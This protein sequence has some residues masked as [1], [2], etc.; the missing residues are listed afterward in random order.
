MSDLQIGLAIIGG[1]VIA[2]VVAYNRLQESRFRKRAED[3]LP[4]RGV[5]GAGQGDALLE[6][7]V[8]TRTD[9]IEPHIKPR[10][11]PEAGDTQDVQAGRVEPVGVPAVPA[12]AEDGESPIDYAIAVRCEQPLERPAL[13]Q[14]LEA[15]EGL[16]R[17]AEVSA[18][19]AD[20]I[21]VP[22]ANAPAEASEMRVALQLADRR[23]HVTLQDLEAFQNLVSRW[24]ES[25]GAS[26]A[27]PDVQAYLETA[28][29]LDRFCAEVDVVVGLNVV[30]ASGDP[31]PGGKVRNQ[32]EA[33]GLRL[34]NGVFRCDDAQGMTLFTL[35]NQQGERFDS[36]QPRS[37]AVSGVTLLLD[38]PRLDEGVK[39]FNRMVETGRQLAFALGGTL[40]DDNRT[41]VTETGL[42]QIRTQLRQIYAAMEARGI[43]AGS[44]LALRLFS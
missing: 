13:Q 33:A 6:P 4:N 39:A 43:R 25:A 19:L 38:V 30:A 9:R 7:M 36:D 23:G 35:E 31:F 24:A 27:A 20:G 41:P 12:A 11:H 44:P 5:A 18:S 42:E 29:D 32:A 2:L 28:R 17:R 22:L 14:L 26:V 1:L 8:R 21:W 15:L 34:E 40:V 16:G 3:S 37:A 10:L